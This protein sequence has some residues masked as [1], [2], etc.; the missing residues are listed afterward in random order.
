MVWLKSPFG[1]P[2]S[3]CRPRHIVETSAKKLV[4]K[5]FSGAKDVKASLV[6]QPLHGGGYLHT[7]N[8]DG[9]VGILQRKRNDTWLDMPKN[10]QNKC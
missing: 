5:V 1:R 3:D 4:G 6:S 10:I 7:S 8:N 9:N 2:S